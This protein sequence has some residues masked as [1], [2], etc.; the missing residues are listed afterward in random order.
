M[1]LTNM[2]L[3]RLKIVSNSNGVNSNANWSIMFVIGLVSNSNGVN[4]NGT[5][6]KSLDKCISVS[7]SNG[8]NSN[9]TFCNLSC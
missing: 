2:R 5:S 4:S 8:V 6:N 7:N 9:F 3:L 1:F